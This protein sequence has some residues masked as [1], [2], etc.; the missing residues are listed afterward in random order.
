MSSTALV[1]DLKRA[2]GARDRAGANRA[3]AALTEAGAPLGGQWLSLARL[4]LH[5]GELSLALKAIDRMAAD[6]QGEALPQFHKASILAQSGRLEEAWGIMSAL[7]DDVP[8][9]LGGAYLRG[10]MAI[11]RGDLPLAQD[12]LARA[13][14]INPASGQ[15]WL[16]LAMAG[17]LTAPQQASMQAASA[18]IAAVPISEQVNY[19][20]ALGKVAHDAQDYEAARDAF[21]RGAALMHREQP[22]DPATDLANAR[23]ALSGYGPELVRRL[24]HDVASSGVDEGRTIIV[25][26]L[27]RSGTTLVE[28]ILTSHSNVTG[29]EELSRF[30]LLVQDL[31]GSSAEFLAKWQAGGNPLSALTDL[32]QH[33]VRERFGP[34]GLVVDKT[35]DAS[36]YLGLAAIVQP[37]API[38]WL[39]R[40]PLDCAWSAYRTFFVRGLPWSWDMAAIAYHMQL[41]DALCARWQEIL[42]DRLL[43]VDYTALVTQPQAQI[44]RLLSHCNLSPEPQVY[45]PHLAKR[46]V[47]TASVLQVRQPINLKGLGV[48]A[49]YRK[50]LAP[51][52]VA[53]R[54]PSPDL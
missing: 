4:A 47:V 52:E 38:V 18:L 16:A 39:R 54:L 10:T 5:N 26:G 29:G 12:W 19:H 53:Y 14:E 35:L 11:N 6:L 27:P 48:A 2:L 8:D 32:Y 42:G 28:Q 51:F 1:E 17:P 13:V 34:E 7:P 45:A 40:D 30:R 46:N 36:R 20:Y 44:D 43:I 31:G 49:P 24:S 41:E 50:A 3:V 33:L 9:P 15:S 22:Y 21:A 23:A 37:A 25:T